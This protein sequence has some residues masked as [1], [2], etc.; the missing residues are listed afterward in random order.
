[1]TSEKRYLEILDEA[2]EEVK[3][4]Y[5]NFEIGIIYNALKMFTK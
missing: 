2:I 3:K 1:M 5:P 4:T